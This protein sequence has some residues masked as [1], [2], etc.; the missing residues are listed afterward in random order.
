MQSHYSP[1]K[2]NN[3]KYCNNPRIYMGN[4]RKLVIKVQGAHYL[5]LGEI[6]KKDIFSRSMCSKD[7][8]GT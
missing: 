3:K 8:E 6:F 4:Y 1:S 5:L 2:N 7:Y